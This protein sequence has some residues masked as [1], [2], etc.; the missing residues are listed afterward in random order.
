M[1][2]RYL[3]L[4]RCKRQIVYANAR[5]WQRLDNGDII[6][7]TGRVDQSVSSEQFQ[8]MHFEEDRMKEELPRAWSTERVNLQTLSNEIFLLGVVQRLYGFPDVVVGDDRAAVAVALNFQRGHF[9]SAHPERINVD[10]R[11][12]RVCKRRKG[13]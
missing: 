2:K 4:E 13:R 11:S 1:E 10:G 6:R 9:Q 5:Q 12:H 7:L 8:R 3:Y